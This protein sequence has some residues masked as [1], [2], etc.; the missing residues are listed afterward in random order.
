[1]TAVAKPCVPSSLDI[2][3]YNTDEIYTKMQVMDLVNENKLSAKTIKKL[4]K[5]YFAEVED[6]NGK[7]KYLRYVLETFTLDDRE[8][9]V[10]YEVIK[11]AL[12]NP[13]IDDC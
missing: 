9:K 2:D 4:A 5:Q 13:E 6:E 10:I 1:M 11:Q 8:L 7:T 3:Y 12:H